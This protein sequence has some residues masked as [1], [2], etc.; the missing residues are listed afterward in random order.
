MRDPVVIIGIGEMGGVFARGLLRSGHPLYP[1]TRDMDLGQ[2]ARE[3]PE[4]TLVLI[5]VAEADLPPVMQR[6]PVPWRQRV[7]LVQNELLPADWL[8][9]RLDSPTVISVWFEKKPGQEA[10]VILPSP[11]YGPHS[12]LLLHALD[13]I[14][15]PCELLTDSDELLF[16]LVRKNLYILT[17]NIAGLRVG[18]TVGELWSQHEALARAVAEDVLGIQAA[19]TDR[20]DL[21]AEQLIDAMVEAFDGDPSHKCMGRSAPARLERALAIA[22]EYGLTVPTLREI[23]SEERR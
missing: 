15:I 19:L 22:D 16:Q 20:N 14:G 5:T 12:G 18:G 17:S 11:V 7:G 8:R 1:V 3:I 4:P 10:K 23:A 13:A 21:P 9:A 6:L 2:A